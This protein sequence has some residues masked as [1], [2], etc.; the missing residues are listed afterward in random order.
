MADSDGEFVVGDLSDDDIEDDL[1]DGRRHG[2]RSTG[3]T[4]GPT[5]SSTRGGDRDGRSIRRKARW[6]DMQ[7]SWDILVENAD[8]NVDQIVEARR[9]A[10]I[11][12]R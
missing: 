1:I 4:R 11:R 7:K 9:E 2:T 12:Q 6:E 8:D 5:G 10:N 3:R